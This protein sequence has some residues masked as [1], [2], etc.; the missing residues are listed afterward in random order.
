M[1]QKLLRA[2]R[3]ASE[4]QW[5]ACLFMGADRDSREARSGLRPFAPYAGPPARFETRGGAA[6]AV[7][8]ASEVLWRDDRG[9]LDRLPYGDDRQHAVTAPF[10]IAHAKRLVA[11]SNTLWAANDADGSL[12]G[13]DLDNLS[14][15]LVV[16]IPNAGILD[17]A[18]DGHD[19]LFVLLQRNGAW[20]I[21][22]YDCAGH[23]KPGFLLEGVSAPSELV[24]LQRAD[25]LVVLAEK[26][27][28]LHW[29]P[30]EGGLAKF[31]LPVTAIRPCFDVTALGGDG[32]ARLALAGTDGVAFGGLHH[33]LSLDSDGNLLGDVRIDEKPTG[34]TADRAHLLVTTASGLQQFDTGQSVSRESSEV[35]AALITP[36]LQSPST[37]DARRWLRVEATVKLPPGSTIEISVASTDNDEIRGEAL[38][39]TA[40]PSLPANQRMYRLRTLLGQWQTTSFHGSETGYVDETIPLSAPIFDVKDQYLWVSV[41]LIAS[42]GGGIPVLS[43]LAVLYPGHS[44]MENLPAVYQRVEAQPGSFLRSLVGVLESTTQTLDARIA[45]MGRNVNPQTAPDKW[46]DFVASWLGLPW[47]D[48]LSTDQKRGIAIRAADIARGRGTRAGLEALLESL[49]PGQPPRFRVVDATADFGLATIGDDVCAGSRLPVMLGGLPSTATELGNKA[50]LGKARLPCPE[51]DGAASR[52]VGRIRVDVSANADE[53]AKWKPWL[54][55]LIDDM[56]PVT[57]RT[58]LRWLSAA[59]F[60]QDMQL[61]DALQLDE[62]PVP[63]LGT[64]AVTGIARLP[65]QRGISLSGPGADSNSPLY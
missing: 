40:D 13:F 18:G 49:M 63:H 54:R 52:L 7:T 51:G 65:G 2:Y 56:M 47:D 26:R 17:I 12:Q 46:L 3:F 44:L 58:Q 30:P 57:A 42:P 55:A 20:E 45:D 33:V 22:R 34:V 10:A 64:D 29:F 43:E 59:A 16:E 41:A 21:A 25:R 31:S 14:R 23:V 1:S 11:T 48:A 38:R 9:M 15:Q 35:R 4:A 50:I 60:R 61:D 28:K 8:Q 36:M 6:P 24:Y 19:G 39:L 5:N 62:A 27:S 53:E 37:A 32:C